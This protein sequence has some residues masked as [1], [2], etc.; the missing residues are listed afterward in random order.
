MH[1]N[2]RLIKHKNRNDTY[3]A[4]HEVFYERR[5]PIS[6]TKEPVTILDVD[7]K[8][9]KWTLKH[10]QSALKRPIIDYSYFKK[11]EKTNT[12]ESK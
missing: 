8:G 12:K 2:F 4:I 5:I 3:L 6:C 11:L 7:I 10:M 9:I 1:W